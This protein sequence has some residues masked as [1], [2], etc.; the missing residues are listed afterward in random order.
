MY[1]ITWYIIRDTSF[2]KV[3][4]IYYNVSYNIITNNTMVL[5]IY[6]IN[7][8][9]SMNCGYTIYNINFL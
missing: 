5:F 8:T 4:I 3:S 1:S 9:Y 2:I 6:S 7:T